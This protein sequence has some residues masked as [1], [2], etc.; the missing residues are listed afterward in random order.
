M[1][2]NKSFS[3][4]NLSKD[5]KKLFRNLVKNKKKEV[6]VMASIAFNKALLNNI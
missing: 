6:N 2:N 3:I 4:A 5:K 1:N